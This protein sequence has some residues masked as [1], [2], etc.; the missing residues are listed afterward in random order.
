MKIEIVKRDFPLEGELMKGIEQIEG[1]G[2]AGV[3]YSRG[4]PADAKEL[5]LML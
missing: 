2:G 5:D 3:V 4:K 1:E